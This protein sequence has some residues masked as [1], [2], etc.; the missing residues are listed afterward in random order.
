MNSYYFV[1]GSIPWTLFRLYITGTLNS[2][3]RTRS[4]AEV[5]KKKK[6]RHHFLPFGIGSFV[7]WLTMGSGDG[8]VE[9]G[10]DES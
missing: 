6:K 2:I 7:S 9:I 10:I 8:T 1:V 4:G 3:K 5:E